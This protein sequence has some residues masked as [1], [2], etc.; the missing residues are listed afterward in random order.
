MF[1][2]IKKYFASVQYVEQLLYQLKERNQTIRILTEQNTAI[3]EE[4]KRTIDLQIEAEKKLEWLLLKNA[5]ESKNHG[6]SEGE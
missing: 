2:S 3:T 5:E 4:W 1:I 6:L